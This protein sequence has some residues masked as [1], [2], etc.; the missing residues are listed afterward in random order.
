MIEMIVT[1]MLILS[2]ANNN[3]SNKLI[4][5]RIIFVTVCYNCYIYGNVQLCY[6]CV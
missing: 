3:Y 5:S 6:L 4:W 2:Y 1:V